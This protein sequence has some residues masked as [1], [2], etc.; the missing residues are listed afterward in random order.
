MKVPTAVEEGSGLPE[1]IHH[2]YSF[3]ILNTVSFTLAI[4]LPKLLFL[5]HLGATATVLGIAASL[6]ALLSILQIPAAG[7]VEKTGYRAFALRGWTIRSFFILGM[8]GVPVLSLFLA[9]MASIALML[10]FLVGYNVSRGLSLCA[11]PP[12]ITRL[13]PEAFRGHF[14]SRQQTCNALAACLTMLGTALLFRGSA[15]TGSYTLAFS[16]SFVAAM[17]SLYFLRSIPDVPVAGAPAAEAFAWNWKTL[18]ANRPFFLLLVYNMVVNAAFAANNVFWMPTLRDLYHWSDTRIL[19]LSS[20][21]YAVAMLALWA[22]GRILDR[23]GS[24]PLL[25][26]SSFL[27][28]VHFT[29]WAAVA[30]GW[31]K[32]RFWNMLFLQ[33]ASAGVSLFNLANARLLMGTV[34]AYAR[35]HFFA[36]YNVAINLTLGLLPIAWGIALD[37]LVRMHWTLAGGDFNRYSLLYATLL[38]IM[39]CSLL[40]LRKLQEARAMTTEA[41]FYE[42]LVRTPGRAVSRFLPGGR[43]L[44]P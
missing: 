9:P 2:A 17:G 1:D 10:L 35:S 15:T 33:L 29:L 36:L 11:F 26:L 42:L 13:V 25:A 12:W 32:P 37:G 20:T 31:L 34:P 43:R 22:F 6:P 27:L 3:E 24:R 30:T 23:V 7:L 28:I 8:I 18:S 39:L 44:L 21:G 40:G 41:F 5:K 38:G 4:G 16:I 19:V 14:L